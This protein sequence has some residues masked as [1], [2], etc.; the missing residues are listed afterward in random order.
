MYISV[1][2]TESLSQTYLRNF[3]AIYLFL[4]KRVFINNSLTARPST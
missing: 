4:Q 2:D 3:G 1:F